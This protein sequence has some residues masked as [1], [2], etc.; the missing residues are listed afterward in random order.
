MTVTRVEERARVGPGTLHSSGRG[1]DHLANALPATGV[2]RAG[3]P[4]IWGQWRGQSTGAEELGAMGAGFMTS[5]DPGRETSLVGHGQ[6]TS[7]QPGVGQ[8]G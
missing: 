2:P 4:G 7:D 6:V 8:P 3:G 1:A 5:P